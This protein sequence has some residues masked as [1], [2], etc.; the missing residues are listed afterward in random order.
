MKDIN[1]AP[2]PQIKNEEGKNETKEQLD[3]TLRFVSNKEAQKVFEVEKRKVDNQWEARERVLASV[4]DVLKYF[5]QNP[6]FEI[7]SR[8]KI[9][10]C[11]YDHGTRST[12]DDDW[13]M[14]GLRYDPA[15]KEWINFD[16]VMGMYGGETPSMRRKNCVVAIKS[17]QEM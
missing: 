3:F 10:M 12:F 13:Y 2:K 4:K 6:D 9:I 15:K 17:Q 11:P 7:E 16:E 1:A 5:K 8:D 14:A